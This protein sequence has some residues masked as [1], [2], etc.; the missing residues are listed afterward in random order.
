MMFDR[1]YHDRHH[2]QTR[3]K[4]RMCRMCR[5]CCTDQVGQGRYIGAL[6]RLNPKHSLV[7]FEIHEPNA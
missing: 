6:V 2:V 3:R 1:K 5:M 7:S 4:G